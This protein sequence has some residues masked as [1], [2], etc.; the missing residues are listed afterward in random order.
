MGEITALLERMRAGD[1]GAEAALY[2]ALYTELKRLARTHLAR[3]GPIT[4][5]PTALIHEVWLRS[6]GQLPAEGRR[7]LF[8]H[9]GVVMRSVI[10]DHV[11]RRGAAKRGDGQQAV[12]LSTGL[13]NE[14]PA[15]VDMLQL[16]DALQA[17]QRVDERAHRVVE[18]RYFAGLTMEE[19]AEA[20]GRSVPSLQRDWRRARAFLFSRLEGAQRG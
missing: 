12:T 4:L 13:L 19:M 9:A 10:V 6:R 18:L 14:Q 15:P 3:A 1:P 16:D 2:D 20:T 17:L 7:Q 11:R 8:A 5:D